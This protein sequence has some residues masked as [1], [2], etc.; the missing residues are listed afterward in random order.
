MVLRELLCT[1]RFVL[2]HFAK[3]MGSEHRFSPWL[4]VACILLVERGSAW[5][6]VVAARRGA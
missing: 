5:C 4:P 3:L 6:G 1:A 2:P